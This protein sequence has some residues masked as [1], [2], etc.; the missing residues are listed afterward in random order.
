MSDRI[1]KIKIKQSDGTFSDYIPI[2]ADAKNIDTTRGESVQ[3]A[4]DKTARYYNSIAEMKLDDNIQIGDTC[5]TLGYYEV[6]DGGGAT[7]KII[8]DSSLEDDG[9]SIHELNNGLK[10]KL[11]IKDNK[12]MPEQFGAYGDGEHDDTIAFQNDFNYSNNVCCNIDKKYL[13]SNKIINLNE[14]ISYYLDLNSSTLIDATFSYNLN[15]DLTDWR[16]SYSLNSFTIKNGKF[17]EYLRLRNGQKDCAILAGGHIILENV[18]FQWTPHIIALA[19]EFIDQLTLT[20]IKNSIYNYPLEEFKDLDAIN[21]INRDSGLIQRTTSQCYTQ[22]DSW[23]FNGLFGFHDANNP[24]YS[25]A[26]LAYHKPISFSNCIQSPC[27][28]IENVMVNF[29]SCHFEGNFSNPKFIGS[30][31][32]SSSINFNNCEF[33][34]DIN[35]IDLRFVTYNNCKFNVGLYGNEKFDTVFSKSFYNYLCTF[36]N[37]ITTS[38]LITID[39][40]KINDNINKPIIYLQSDYYKE[41]SNTNLEELTL[42]EINASH[43]ID[44]LGVYTFDIFV[45]TSNNMSKYYSH[46]KLSVNKLSNNSFLRSGYGLSF[47]NAIYEIYVTLPNGTIKRGYVRAPLIANICPLNINFY[48]GAS[49]YRQCRFMYMQSCIILASDLDNKEHF[50]YCDCMETVSEIPELIQSSEISKF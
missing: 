36:N 13:L 38:E 32:I 5:I 19:Q 47:T 49:V 33:V 12:V 21:V 11:V 6:N 45:H 23:T 41:L 10:A 31:Y 44:D 25:F 2:G 1:K 17:G 15:D 30:Y 24:N 50:N 4:I 40:K 28:I 27:N 37:C 7:Y 35:I 18:I 39:S 42:K 16:Y 22:G 14:N 46:K 8:D 43:D 29:D 3:L 34:S 9:G 48:S 26:S 20:N